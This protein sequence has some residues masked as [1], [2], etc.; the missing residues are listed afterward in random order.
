VAALEHGAGMDGTGV[1]VL[2]G[3]ARAMLA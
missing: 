1:V 2:H 3:G